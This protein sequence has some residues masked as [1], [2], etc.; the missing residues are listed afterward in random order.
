MFTD[1]A[2]IGTIAKKASALFEIELCESIKLQ[3]SNEKS[4]SEFSKKSNKL[5]AIIKVIL[6][7][8]YLKTN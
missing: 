6:Y 5:Y 2:K 7:K 4:I 3:T 8:N 1:N